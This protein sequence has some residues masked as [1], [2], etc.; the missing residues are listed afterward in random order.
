[1][2]GRMKSGGSFSNPS[3]TRLMNASRCVCAALLIASA[4]A[5]TGCSTSNA[6]QSATNDSGSAA[7]KAAK[8]AVRLLNVSYDP[9][10]EFY[11]EFNKEFAKHWLEKEGQEVTVEQSHGGSGAQARAVI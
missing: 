9:T 5:V 8:P 6:T 1:M 3:G 10:R 7:V 11:A 2:N 4:T